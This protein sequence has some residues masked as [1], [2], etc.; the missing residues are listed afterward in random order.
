[1]AQQITPACYNPKY[2]FFYVFSFI[3]KKSTLSTNKADT[4]RDDDTY[5]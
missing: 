2:K 4:K 1:M 5:T 3:C